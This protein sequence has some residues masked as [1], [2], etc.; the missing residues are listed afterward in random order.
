MRKAFAVLATLLTLVVVA[1]FYFAASGASATGPGG[2][3]Y[4]PHHVLGYVIFLLPVVMVIVGAPAR[5]PGRLI[6][7]TA[8]IAG[9]TAVQVVIAKLARAVG[10]TGGQLVFGLHAVNGLLL[11]AMVMTTLRQ[12]WALARAA[13]PAVPATDA[14]GSGPAAEPVAP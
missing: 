9:L 2:A 10:D 13:A 3:A 7:T 5:I 11:L 14:V 8:G 12:A 6:A 1:E 4:R